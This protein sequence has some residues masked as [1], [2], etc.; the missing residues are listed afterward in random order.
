MS[1]IAGTLKLAII[2][3][4]AF[5]KQTKLQIRHKEN[6]VRAQA[7]RRNMCAISITLIIKPNQ[8]GENYNEEN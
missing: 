7:Q 4:S 5:H 8:K 6:L 3:E 2:I 1:I